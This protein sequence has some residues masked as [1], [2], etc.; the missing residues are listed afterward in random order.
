MKQYAVSN[1]VPN[2]PNPDGSPVVIE[3]RSKSSATTT[4]RVDITYGRCSCPAW[5]FQKGVRKPCKHLREL[6][7]TLYEEPAQEIMEFSEPTTSIKKEAIYA[8]YEDSDEL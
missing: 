7:F 5:K 6:G 2:L 3:V 4:Y 1:T 8:Q